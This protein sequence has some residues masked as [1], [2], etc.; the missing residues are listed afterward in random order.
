MSLPSGDFASARWETFGAVEQN[1]P[2]IQLPEEISTL[3]ATELL[4]TN[5][6]VDQI[7]VVND[8][9]YEHYQDM[10]QEQLYQESTINKID[11]PFE[12]IDPGKNVFIEG[13]YLFD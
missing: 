11:L 7:V 3:L 8:S 6:E 4:A 13:M 1:I 5:F 10:I 2:I 12:P 9:R